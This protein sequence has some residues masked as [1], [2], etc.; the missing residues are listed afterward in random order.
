VK[1]TVGL[2][3]HPKYLEHETGSH[4]ETA[5]RLRRAMS[6]IEASGLKDRLTVIT[7]RA[8]THDELARVHTMDHI[9]GI[10][11]LAA[12]GGGRVDS[13]TVV[14]PASYDAAVLAA[15]GVITAAVEVWQ[16][17]SKHAFALVR[18]PGHHA[19]P[20]RA[21]GF[22][23]FNNV[24]VAAHYLLANGLCQRVAIADF[25]VHHGNGTQDAFFADGRVLYFSSHQMPL[26]PGSGHVREDGSGKGKGLIANAPLPPGCG[27]D[28]YL[29]VYRELFAPLARRFKPDFILVSA[30]Y[31]AHWSD[32]IASEQMTVSGYAQLARMLRDL[33]DEL[34]HGRLV[35]A[36]E[37]GY[38]LKALAASIKATLEVL[39]GD[40]KIEDPLGK[41]RGG[42]HKVDLS[43]LT[44]EV[45]R[46]HG[47]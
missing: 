41:P 10:Q 42:G 40:E 11:A 14:S 46:V 5:D 13:D 25:D 15:G 8:A 30:G 4:P 39:L 2:V 22:C 17:R 24:A 19:T 31:D 37:G 3:Y 38:S 29:M 33:S 35:F 36:L 21:M 12:R 27:D 34:C 45:K 23:L 7:P 6:L 28:E 32:P 47:I 16:A 26:Y 1:D 20:S 9:K 18:P 44:G 43:G